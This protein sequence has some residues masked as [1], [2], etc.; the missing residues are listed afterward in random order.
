MIHGVPNLAQVE[1]GIWRGGQPTA[2]GWSYLKSVGIT[3]SVKLNVGK[4][5]LAE[6]NGISVVYLP[7]DWAE[8]TIWKPQRSTVE[9]AVHSISNGTFV[10]CLHGQDRTG[11]IIGVYR[12]EIEK[13]KKEVA[14]REM[15]TNGFHK[16][17]LGLWR[18][19]EEDVK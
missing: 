18:Y 4:D 19:W 2:E 9:L 7:I 5:A 3:K 8:Q 11:L 16:E 1:S 17:L 12:V 15:L 13:W 10:H 14:E 6:S